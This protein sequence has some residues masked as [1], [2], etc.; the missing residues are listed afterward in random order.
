MET[1]HVLLPVHNRRD[2]TLRF[3]RCLAAQT[4][5][6][7]RLLLIDDGS[8]DG[9]AAAVQAAYPSAD[10]IRGAGSWWWAGC[11]Q[12]GLDRLAQSAI[13]DS[14]IVLFANDDTTFAPD[15]VESAV[16]FLTDRPDCMLLSRYR[17]A[18]TGRIEEA[19]VCADLRALTFRE[20]RTPGEI[21]CL[22]TR[23]LFVR[24]RNV[25]QIGPF[26]TALLPHYWSDYEYTIRAIRKGL[27]PLT[28][29]FVWLEANAASSG[30]RDLAALRGR[31]FIGEFFSKRCLNNPLYKSSFVLLACPPLAI[32]PHIAG[33]WWHALLM[34][35]R[36]GLLPLAPD[37]IVTAFRD[38][39][40]RARRIRNAARLKLQLL[41]VHPRRIVLG[42]GG[43]SPRGWIA[44]DIDQL[45]ISAERDWQRYFSPGSVDAILAEHVWEH[46]SWQDGAAAARLCFKYLRAGGYLRIAVPDGL[47]PDPQYIDAVKPGGTGPGANDHKVLYTCETLQRHLATAGFDVRALEYFDEEGQFHA[48]TWDPADGL[49]RRSARF[50]ERNQDGTLRY[51]SIIVD[52]VKP[53]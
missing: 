28:T 41:L 18:S 43:I 46:L 33:I 31:Q 47:H 40:V 19:G 10:V 8:T 3:V 42:S 20:A 26:H 13:A 52:A 51:T 4:Y 29:E 49:V 11:L 38:L 53:A 27:Q 24:W 39:L 30:T 7:I 22:S 32:A 1:V 12:R 9:T 45:D 16:R 14:D 37:R 35:L 6:A 36:Q 25:R 5:P 50:D 17:D 15:F 23:G 34:V 2:I 21:N 44:T 48:R